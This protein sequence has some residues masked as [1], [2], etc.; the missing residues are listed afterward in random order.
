MAT[1]I[2]SPFPFSD[3]AIEDQPTEALPIIIDMPPACEK[4]IGTAHGLPTVAY[5]L[6]RPLR[7]GEDA[8]MAVLDACIQDLDV[9]LIP[10]FSI[11]PINGELYIQ[12]VPIDPWTGRTLAYEQR[13]PTP[14]EVL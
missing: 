4:V 11:I 12:Y 14:C 7:T 13:W 5:F 8:Y 1:L 6:G 2:K 3:T 9:E 10:P